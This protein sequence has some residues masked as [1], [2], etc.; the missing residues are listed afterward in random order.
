[1]HKFTESLTGY[2]MIAAA[3]VLMLV[4]GFW[5]KKTVAIKF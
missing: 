5:L 3:V 1:M 4:G 2:A